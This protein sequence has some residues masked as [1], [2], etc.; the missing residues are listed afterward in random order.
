MRVAGPASRGPSVGVRV[1]LVGD[2]R[3]LSRTTPPSR[4]TTPPL[5]DS[6]PL[7]SPNWLASE[8]IP[9]LITI[10]RRCAPNQV[11]RAGGG[12][13]N[14]VLAGQ[15]GL[16]L[17]YSSSPALEERRGKPRSRSGCRQVGWQLGSTAPDRLF[18]G[19]LR[20]G[21]ANHLASLIRS[22]CLS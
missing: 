7:P 2:F 11:L 10:A 19:D 9:W 3:N 6:R 8:S 4:C 17:A 15:V 21:D 18:S 16:D 1:T 22:A 14:L 12:A 13:S 20:N 5:V